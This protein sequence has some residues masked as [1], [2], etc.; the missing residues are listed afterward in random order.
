M[1]AMGVVGD[2]SEFGVEGSGIVRRVGSSVDHVQVGQGVVVMGN[3]ILRT[4][5]T[6][7]AES[8]LPLP[9][10]LSL[11]DAATVPCVYA[12]VLYSLVE[13]SKLHQGQSIL[14]HSACG[15]VGLGAIQL[16]QML[17][18]EVC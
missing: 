8:C 18:A 11:A 7:P 17:G 14:I 10:N 3:G 9:H 6:L 2:K 16:S 4:R 12:T 15:G 5:I 1:V 13:I